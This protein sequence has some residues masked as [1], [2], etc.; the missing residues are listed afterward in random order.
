MAVG[1]GLTSGAGFVRGVVN[2]EVLLLLL[3]IA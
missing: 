2:I 3:G 1:G